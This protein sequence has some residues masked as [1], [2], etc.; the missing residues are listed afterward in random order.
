M[1]AQ[2]TAVQV[3]KWQ[4]N[5]N[6]CEK[7]GLQMHVQWLLNCRYYLYF[8]NETGIYNRGEYEAFGSESFSSVVDAGGPRAPELQDLDLTI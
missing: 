4:P 8:Q 5:A 3:K 7:Q 1:F 6:F 2:Q